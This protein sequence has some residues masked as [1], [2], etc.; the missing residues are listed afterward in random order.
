LVGECVR[1]DGASACFQSEFTLNWNKE[2]PCWFLYYSKEVLMAVLSVFAPLQEESELSLYVH[3]AVRCQGVATKLISKAIEVLSG[4]GSP[5]YLLVCDNASASGMAFIAKKGLALHHSEY[6]LTYDQTNAIV[7][8]THCMMI[9]KAIEDDFEPLVG[10]IKDAFGEER[11]QV[12][13]FVRSSMDSVQRD[14]FVGSL[15]GKLVATASVGYDSKEVASINMVAVSQAMQGQGLG[16]EIIQTLIE[17]LVAKKM[18]IVIE[19]FSTNMRAYGLY[20]KIG[21]TETRVV[22]YYIYE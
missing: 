15:D 14:V 19:V 3:P 5:R 7:P 18:E 10:L 2:M 20:K 21:F 9:R 8:V 22:N 17:P 16:K 6:S 1:T 11:H 13:N 12:E 4:Y